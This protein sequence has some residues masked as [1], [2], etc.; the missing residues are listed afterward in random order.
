LPVIVHLF[1]G[2]EWCCPCISPTYT[3]TLPKHSVCG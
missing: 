3:T 1:T 2:I